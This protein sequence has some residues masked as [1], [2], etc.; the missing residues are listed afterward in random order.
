MIPTLQVGSNRILFTAEKH[1]ERNRDKQV[2][3][4]SPPFTWSFETEE[5]SV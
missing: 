4:G 3:A 2:L 5:T 1:T